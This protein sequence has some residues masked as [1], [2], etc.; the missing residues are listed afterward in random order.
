MFFI[1]TEETNLEKEEWITKEVTFIG[2]LDTVH[3]LLAVGE[4]DSITIAIENREQEDLH[5][6]FYISR[7][8]IDAYREEYGEEPPRL[9]NASYAANNL[10]Y[11]QDE[12]Y[13]TGKLFRI[14]VP[15]SG[16]KNK[17]VREAQYI[18]GY[19]AFYDFPEY[20]GE[21]EVGPAVQRLLDEELG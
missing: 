4:I 12:Y 17:I 20:A 5:M 7:L 15:F 10:Y 14:A 13:E 19:R 16:E 3:E 9:L 21:R 8:Y 1:R 18:A 11:L 6:L 2:P